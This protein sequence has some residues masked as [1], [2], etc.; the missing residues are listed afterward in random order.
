MEETVNKVFYTW[1]VLPESEQSSSWLE[2]YL[3]L[4]QVN[5]GDQWQSAVTVWCGY[6]V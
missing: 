5:R 1:I 6:G 3:T 2:L 4:Y